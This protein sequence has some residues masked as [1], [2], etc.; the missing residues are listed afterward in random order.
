MRRNFYTKIGGDGRARLPENTRKGTTP[1]PKIMSKRKRRQG[2]TPAGAVLITRHRASTF[3]F[4]SAAQQ[5]QNR[6][7]H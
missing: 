1:N 6:P 3:V 7:Q 2:K 4:Q 5:R